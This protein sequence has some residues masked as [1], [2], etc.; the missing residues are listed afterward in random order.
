[1]LRIIGLQ[2]S[3]FNLIKYGRIVDPRVNMVIALKVK[4][5]KQSSRNEIA[6]SVRWLLDA[7]Y[8]S[9]LSLEAGDYFLLIFADPA[10]CLAETR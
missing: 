7:Y 10:L 3:N 9:T 2:I 8:F 1:M 5:Q 4:F 6:S